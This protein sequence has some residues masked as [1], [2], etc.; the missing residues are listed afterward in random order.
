MKLFMR[1]DAASYER[2]TAGRGEWSAQRLSSDTRLK[3]KV[4]YDEEGVIVRREYE[5]YVVARW[6]D[7][8]DN[9]VLGTSNGD[10]VTIQSEADWSLSA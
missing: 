3:S 7:G 9:L 2:Y 10:E 5:A 6:L 8:L 1:L 4:L